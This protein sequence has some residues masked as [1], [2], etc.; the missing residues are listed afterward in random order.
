MKKIELKKTDKTI[1]IIAVLV[2]VGLIIFIL[3]FLFVFSSALST[4]AIAIVVIGPII[5]EYYRYKES[6]ETEERFPDFLRDVAE[7]LRAG[8]TLPKAMIATKNNNYG[9]LS[10]YVKK[11]AVEIDWGLPFDKVLLEFAKKS[12][13]V[14]KRTVSTIIEAHESGGSVADIFDATGKTI[15]EINKIRKERVSA[16]YSQVTTGYIIFFVFLGVLIALQKYFIPSIST[17]SSPELGIGNIQGI[18]SLYNELF[19]WLILIQGFFSGLVIGKISEG[20]LIAGLKHCII[21]M[22]LGYNALIIF[23]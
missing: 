18:A 23:V 22:I 13:P 6:K 16:V 8:M 10:P 4:L 11:M 21:L 1:L 17:I 2:A 9:G 15:V 12:T 19:M 5:I 20:R 7:N 14:I 3:N